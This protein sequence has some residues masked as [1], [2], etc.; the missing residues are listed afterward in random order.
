VVLLL[1]FVGVVALLDDVVLLDA[2][3]GGALVEL[4]TVDF[5]SNYY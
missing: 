4:P 2:V 5:V 3:V 1:L